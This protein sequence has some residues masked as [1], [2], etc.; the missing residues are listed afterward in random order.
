MWNLCFNIMILGLIIVIP[1]GVA[2]LLA[3]LIAGSIAGLLPDA[4]NTSRPV[5]GSAATTVLTLMLLTIPFAGC[6]KEPAYDGDCYGN[7]QCEE[8][9]AD[10]ESD[11]GCNATRTSSSSSVGATMAVGAA[12]LLVAS[13]RRRKALLLV[14]T[15]AL[16]ALPSLAFAGGSNYDDGPS[17]D[18]T[19][20][21]SFIGWT[22]LV[23]LG[24]AVLLIIVVR[25]L[26]PPPSNRG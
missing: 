20:F 9:R 4:E 16:L 3:R 15:V 13:R 6:G 14:C 11:S 7:A 26:P 12:L 10:E 24:S 21:F 1:V 2:T 22:A 19:A 23:M 25:F 17:C 5:G 18:P 8:S